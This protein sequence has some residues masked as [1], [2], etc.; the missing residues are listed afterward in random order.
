[1]KHH[2]GRRAIHPCGAMN[3]SETIHWRES[4]KS[5]IHYAMN[6]SG[7]DLSALAG[8]AENMA[9]TA[10]LLTRPRGRRNNAG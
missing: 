1:M 8:A 10:T 7:D 3:K 4:L 6:L 9:E 5:L 2:A